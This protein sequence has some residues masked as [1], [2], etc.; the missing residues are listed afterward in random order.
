MILGIK[1]I[2]GFLKKPTD[3]RFDNQSF[4]NKAIYVGKFLLIDIIF[5]LVIILPLLNLIEMFEPLE[6]ESTIFYSLSKFHIS[7]LLIGLAI[8]ILEELVFRLFLRYNKLFSKFISREKWNK[9]FPILTYISILSFGVVHATNYTNESIL[10][11]VLIPFIV[12]T[13]SVGG[14]LLAFLRVRFNIYTSIAFHAIFNSLIVITMYIGQIIEK[15]YVKEDEYKSVNIKYLSFMSSNEQIFEVD[16]LNGKIF[17]V[18]IQDYT[19][20]H[21]YDSLLKIERNQEDFLLNLNI[22]S[23]KGLS[24]KEIQEILDQYVKDEEL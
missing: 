21:V 11:Y 20:N 16:S 19:M 8:P 9:I 5:N 22:D 4:K 2:I 18:K 12:L 15:P 24:L 1:E 14:V 13:Q 10:F 7:L 3:K 17:Q 23:S 6:E